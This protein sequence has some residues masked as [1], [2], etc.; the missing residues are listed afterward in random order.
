MMFHNSVNIIPLTIFLKIKFRNV[1]Q[2]FEMVNL[3]I[4]NEMGKR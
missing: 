1:N 2:L 4:Y 3:I